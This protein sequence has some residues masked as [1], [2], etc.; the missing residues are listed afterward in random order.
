MVDLDKEYIKLDIGKVVDH[1][2]WESCTP[3]DSVK[4]EDDCSS[5]VHNIGIGAY[6]DLTR[7]KL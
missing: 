6:I 2:I 5:L 3:T 7:V 1:I 4:S